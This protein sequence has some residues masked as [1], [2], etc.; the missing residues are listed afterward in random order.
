MIHVAGSGQ[1]VVSHIQPVVFIVK[2]EGVR[3]VVGPQQ[4]WNET[5]CLE[6]GCV[7][8]AS[9][10]FGDLGKEEV[11]SFRESA[12]VFFVVDAEKFIVVVGKST[13]SRSFFLNSN[14]FTFT[15]T[16]SHAFVRDS[17][18]IIDTSGLSLHKSLYLTFALL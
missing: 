15:E 5:V 4:V 16:V 12:A 13:Q 1:T 11:D 17:A 2:K 10:P 6:N 9:V 3:T 8:R 14:S 7:V 18:G